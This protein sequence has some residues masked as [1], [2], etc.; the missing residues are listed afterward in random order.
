MA[1]K[2]GWLTIDTKDVEK[3]ASFWESALPG[4]K[5]VY[6]EAGGEVVLR[7]PEGL[8]LLFLAVPDDKVVKNR[9][10]FDLIPGDRDAEV[11]RLQGLGA[12]RVNVGQ[13]DDVSWVVMADPEGNEFCVLGRP[14]QPSA[15]KIGFLNIDAHDVPKLVSFWEQ[16]LPGSE[17]VYEDA[18]IGE[19]D[20][21]TPDAWELAFFPVPDA[22]VVKNRW[23]LDLIPDDLDAEVA[24]LEGLGATR[25]DIGQGDVSWVVM[26]DPE[27]NEFCVLTARDD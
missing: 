4:S 17:R 15:L 22:K 11:A 16:A 21:K 8:Q 23:H 9:L 6:D 27:G 12:T 25:V 18:D 10:H 2:V 13:P 5:R 14:K 19:I 7:T 1:V 26:A 24:R 20:I 3:L